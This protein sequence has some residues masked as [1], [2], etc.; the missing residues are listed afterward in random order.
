VESQGILTAL[1]ILEQVYVVCPVVNI[2]EMPYS[3]FITDFLREAHLPRVSALEPLPD[4]RLIQRIAVA[5]DH[6]IARANGPEV[7]CI[8]SLL[9]IAAGGV[10]QAHRIVQEISTN[11]AAYIHGIIHRID[12]DFD[13]ARYWFRRAGME[14]ASAEIYRRA[15]AN[16]PTI[17]SHPIWD[18]ILVTDMVETSRTA[19][20]TDELRVLLTIEFEV[21]LQ[22]LSNSTEPENLA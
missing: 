8:R 11:D 18:P 7:K 3:A 6:E 22:F 12:D 16:S 13:N 20:V 19:G 9:F 1:R 15:A 4:K 10:E 17:A 21:L 5:K 2:L 14:P